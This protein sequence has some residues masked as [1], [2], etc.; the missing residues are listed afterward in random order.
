MSELALE[1]F[2]FL[3]PWW[4]LVIP[5]AVW[6]YFILRRRFNAADQWKSV[7]QSDLLQ[8]LTVAG[9]SDKFIRPY[10]LLTVALTLASVALAGPTWQ[11]VITPFTQDK[12]PFIIALQMT[13]TMLATD[14]QPTRLERAKQKIRDLLD[15][16]QGART[17]VVAYAGSAHPVLPLTDDVGLI[18]I[19]LESMLPGVMPLDGNDPAAALSLAENMLATEDAVGTILFMTDGIDR[20]ASDSFA[21]HA[22]KSADQV[23]FLGFGDDA[24]SPIK[25]DE[26]GGRSFGLIDGIAPPI[27]RAGLDAVA[28]ASGTS[29][30]MVTPD[31]AD[32]DAI[33]RRISTNLVSSIDEDENLQW[34]DFGYYLI[35]PL[36]FLVLLWSRR[37]WTVRWL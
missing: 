11:R 6:L 14:Q 33:M 12:S 9:S 35:W 2:H 30:V 27:D 5:F 20:T 4:L 36:M 22:A 19:Y 21:E 13:P 29:L 15:K 10:Q 23:L 1:N 32:V 31:D 34:R 24:E 3:R 8:H 28:S 17:A 7:I 26:A 18:E 37:G 16:R 25:S